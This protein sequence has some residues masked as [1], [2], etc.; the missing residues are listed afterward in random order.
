MHSRN[1]MGIHP[2]LLTRTR[3]KSVGCMKSMNQRTD[4][5]LA[6][7]F[8]GAATIGER[9]QIVIPAE[10]RA[11]LNLRAGEKVLI[12]RHPVHPGLMIFKLEAAREFIDAFNEGLQQIESQEQETTEK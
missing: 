5:C 9:G 7:A 3:V 8:F 11:E 1:L 4:P 12:M 2:S 10:A 6:T